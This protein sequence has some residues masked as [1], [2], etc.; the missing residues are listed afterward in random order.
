MAT[1]QNEAQAVT[2]L[3]RFG[4]GA[5]PGGLRA[6]AGDPRGFL[7]E[8]LL[9]VNSVDAVAVVAREIVAAHAVVGLDE[10]D[11]RLDRGPWRAERTAR[12][13]AG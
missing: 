11:V 4:L 7:I 8:E 10:T 5:R 9:T 12:P 13:W 2:A 6:A 1:G 3:N